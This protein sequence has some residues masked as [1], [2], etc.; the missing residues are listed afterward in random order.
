[1]FNRLTILKRREVG[2]GIADRLMAAEHAIDL[3]IARTADL[4][5][6]MPSVRAEA[7]LACEVGQEAL[8]HAV[9]SFSAL[10]KARASM[11]ASHRQL[12]VTK[13]EI[14]LRTVS[15]G[16]LVGKSEEANIRHLSEVAKSAA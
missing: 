1:M 2:Q 4:T 11:I 10:V 12:A 6:Y 15:F 16:G 5:G 3:A 9:A 8:E 7:N 14:G 13:D